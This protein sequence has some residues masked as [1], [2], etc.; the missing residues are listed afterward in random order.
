MFTPPPRTLGR[1]DQTSYQ[2]LLN[3][4][5]LAIMVAGT[6]MVYVIGDNR[7]LRSRLTLR[8]P[9]RTATISNVA[10]RRYTIMYW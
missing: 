3:R 5:R 7:V 8:L 4:S 1:A 2:N 6:R 9:C 10:A